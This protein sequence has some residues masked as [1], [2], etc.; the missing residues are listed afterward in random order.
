MITSSFAVAT[1]SSTRFRPDSVS[2]LCPRRLY[3]DPRVRKMEGLMQH[4]LHLKLGLRELAAAIALSP[5][6]FSHLFKAQTGLSP[7]QYLKSI[8][9]QRAKELLETSHLS[10]K[11][12]A[13]HVGLDSSQ[14]SKGFRR[15]YGVTPLQHRFTAFDQSRG[16]YMGDTIEL[17]GK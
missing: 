8:R 13:S 15:T 2:L 12:V 11:E 9:I 10:I 6:R 17:T 5:S 14:L 7:S 4:N 1:E 16:E 3:R